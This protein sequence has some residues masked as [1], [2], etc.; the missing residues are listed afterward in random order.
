MVGLQIRL[1]GAEEPRQ[2]GRGSLV[3]TLDFVC[4]HYFYNSGRFCTSCVSKGFLAIQNQFT[5][6]MSM[7]KQHKCRTSTVLEMLEG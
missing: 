7:Q 2:P 6:S 5:V 1:A 4:W 3:V